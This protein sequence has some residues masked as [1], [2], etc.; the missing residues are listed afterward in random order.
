MIIH[1]KNN[2]LFLFSK[3]VG[4]EKVQKRLFFRSIQSEN[5]SNKYTTFQI[6]MKYSQQLFVQLIKQVTM[7]QFIFVRIYSGQGNFRNPSRKYQKK[8]S[9]ISL[10][11]N[12]TPD[13]HKRKVA[14][15]YKKIMFVEIE[16]VFFPL[17]LFKFETFQSRI[18]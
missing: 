3:V 10:S 9:A 17:L 14:I 8:N 12:K 16:R 6:E 18:S 4:S 13:I 7:N 5:I 1:R 2:W 11:A 15:G